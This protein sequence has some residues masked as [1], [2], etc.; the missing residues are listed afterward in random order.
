[1]KKI[2]FHKPKEG[3]HREKKIIQRK[4]VKK[5]LSCRRVPRRGQ[6][7]LKTDAPVEE[8]KGETGDEETEGG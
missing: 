5:K 2:I 1:M 6:G 4:N 8:R 3:A 7:A